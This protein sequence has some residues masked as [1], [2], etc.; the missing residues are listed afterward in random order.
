[1]FSLSLP[2][3]R[4]ILAAIPSSLNKPGGRFAEGCRVNDAV[5]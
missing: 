4:C 5:S 3:S 1:M 2:F